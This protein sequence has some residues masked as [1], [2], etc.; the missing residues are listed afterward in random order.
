A[1]QVVVDRRAV[2]HEPRRQAGEDRDQRRAV[3]LARGDELEAHASKPTAARITP[4]GAGIPVQSSN[5]FAPWATSTSSPLIT[6]APAAR[7]A[8]PVAVSG[9]GRSTRVRP[10]DRAQTTSSRSDVAWTTRSASAVS[11][12]QS[13]RREKTRACGSAADH[14]AAAPPPP[15]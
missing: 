14:A 3:R 12:G 10:P 5:A 2:E 8:R 6:R 9:Y 7:A 4:T 15:T 13:P 1:A 11:G